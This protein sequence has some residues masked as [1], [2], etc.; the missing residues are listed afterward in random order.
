MSRR[1]KMFSLLMEKGADKS[2]IILEELYD[3]DRTLMDKLR[4]FAG[5]PRKSILVVY[6]CFSLSLSDVAGTKKSHNPVDKGKAL[7]TSLRKEYLYK[8]KVS[9]DERLNSEIATVYYIFQLWK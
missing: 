1:P 8:H 4:P 7:I 2:K 6:S 3:G 5:L 9:F